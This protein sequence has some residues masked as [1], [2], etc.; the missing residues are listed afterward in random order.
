MEP[1]YRP[2][3]GAALAVFRVMDWDVRTT[4]SEHIPRSGPAI[5]AANHVG[6]LDFTFLG[7]GGHR[8]GRF[9]RFMAMQSAFEH[10]LGGPLLRGMKHIPVDREGDA[11]ASLHRAAAALRRGEVVGIHP[12]GAMS[13]SFVPAPGKTG[14]ARL[15]IETGAPLIPAAVW[16]SQ[17]ILAPGRRRKWPRHV[18]VTVSFGEGEPCPPGADAEAVTADLMER[19]G[20]LVAA[21]AAAYPQH[22]RVASDRWWVPAHLGGTAPS[23]E[24]SLAMAKAAS[25]SRRAR[26]EQG[27][28]P[29]PRG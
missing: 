22:P 13:R 18:V 28:D 19:I 7:L 23:E 29:V 9:V 12:E 1:V 11:R 14:A 20:G 27:S 17:R 4:G 26:R 10:W 16:G 5:I 15:A 8:R 24:Q 6:Y 21:A 2:V 3:I 25:A